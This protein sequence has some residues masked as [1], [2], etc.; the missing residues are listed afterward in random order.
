[1]QGAFKSA[2][3]LHA[4]DVTL[5]KARGEAIPPPLAAIDGNTAPDVRT[6]DYIKRALDR[7]IDAGYSGDSAAKMQIP[8]LKDARNLLLS[9]VDEHVPDFAAARAIY[10]GTS[11]NREA[12]EMGQKM[13]N[14]SEGDIA[15]ATAKMSE[16]ERAQF[17]L[18]M[19]SKLSENLSRRTDL[20][21]KVDYLSNS[22]QRR[23]ILQQVAG[24]DANFGQFETALGHERALQDT[25]SNAM[26]GSPTA[27][28]LA[29]DKILDD[30]G[31]AQGVLGRFARGSRNG[32][33]S[34]ITNAAAPLMDASRFGAGKTGER[35]RDQIA[36]LLTETD[37]RVFQT[38][39]DNA[40]RDAVKRQVIA[41]RLGLQTG[42]SLAALAGRS[43]ADLR[44]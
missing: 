37:P 25:Y 15:H 10:A 44:Q 43:I 33:W 19:R 36:T 3:E 4:G 34:G 12:L 14:A 2:Q 27:I 1:L 9:R 22:P 30:A 16:G 32:L 24:P 28:N 8:F 39:L 42:N 20:G 41:G 26:T 13:V 40:Q 5:A 23:D 38:A 7:K 21:N 35:V 29:D 11:K 17:S 6:I 18:G 31:L